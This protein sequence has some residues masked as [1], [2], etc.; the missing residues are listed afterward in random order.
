MTKK[1]KKKRIKEILIF[2]QNQ[3][4]TSQDLLNELELLINAIS[5]E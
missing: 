3:G 4:Y 1:E 5:K 2:L